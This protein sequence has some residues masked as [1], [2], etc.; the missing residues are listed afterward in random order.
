M[1]GFE[2]STIHVEVEF[3]VRR[4]HK[5][6]THV[7]QINILI[8]MYFNITDLHSDSYSVA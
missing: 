8:G 5:V 1:D 3:K 4:G 6:T 7:S 2:L